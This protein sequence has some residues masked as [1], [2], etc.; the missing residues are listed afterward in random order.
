MTAQ[1]NEQS[2]FV[3]QI[4]DLRV[5]TGTATVSRAGQCLQLPKLSFDLLL[6]LARAAPNLVA[7]DELMDRVWPG[8]VVE[9]DTVSQRVTL[10]RKALGD[11]PRRPRYISG[12]RGR[13]YRLACPVTR[14]LATT[15]GLDAATT[16]AAVSTSEPLPESPS[17]G[18]PT[19]SNRRSATW[20]GTARTTA[21]TRAA[22]P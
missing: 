2:P 4:G 19:S 3:L 1:L 12:V 18:T 10:L 7:I 5:D 17:T 13:G 16:P 20:S 15:N 6:A 22:G 21:R 8:L 9:A 14:I 11:D